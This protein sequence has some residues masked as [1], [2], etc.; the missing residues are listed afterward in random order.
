MARR[1]HVEWGEPWSRVGS[2]AL[3]AFLVAVP[4]ALGFATGHS[5]AG[6]VGALGAYLWT[7]SH[8]TDKRPVGLPIGVVTALLLGLAGVTGALGGRYLWFL[9]VMVVLWASAQAVTDVAGGPLRVP[10]ALSALCMLLSAIDGGHTIT[11]A[12]WQGLLTLGGAAWIT[13]TDLVRHPPWRS[14]RPAAT[15]GFKALRPAWPEGR[16]FALLLVIPTALVAGIAGT[17]QISH[18]AWM[19]TTVLRVL[20]PDRASTVTRSKQRAV[21]TVVGAI[22]AAV[23]LAAAPAAV[24]AVAVVVVA[25]TAMQLVGPRRYGWYTFF[26]TLIALQLS[27]IGHPRDWGIALIRAVLTLVGT[28]VAVISGLIYDRVT[29]LTK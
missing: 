14:P 22:L 21:G 27:S 11:G 23:L 26:L 16:R 28:A 24:T 7:A 5:V 18:G 17:F 1:D 19:A 13:G 3:T 15:M 4:L 29:R 2:S 25:V 9:V 10:V 6:G 8:I 20:R 12:L